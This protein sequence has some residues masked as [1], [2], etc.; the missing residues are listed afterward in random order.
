MVFFFFYLK[1]HGKF[2][3]R[4]RASFIHDTKGSSKPD[5]TEKYTTE[6]KIIQIG[7]FEIYMMK[8]SRSA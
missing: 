2:K 6:K 7:P 1:V 8:L 5:S 3:T 4:N